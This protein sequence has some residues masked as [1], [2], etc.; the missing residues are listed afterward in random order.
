MNSNNRGFALI[1][2]L[3]SLLLISITFG[4]VATGVSVSRD[5]V[6]ST[7]K[8]I[9]RAIAYSIDEATIRNSLI[10][11]HFVFDTEKQKILVEG[12]E[13]GNFMLPKFL[14]TSS[15]DL[16]KE[17]LAN[18]Q[19]KLNNNFHPLKEFQDPVFE[20]EEDVRII[21]IATSISRQ[22]ITEGDAAVYFYPTGEKMMLSLSSVLMKRLLQSNFQLI[23]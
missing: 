8:E 12:G 6:E 17:E 10:R 22:L 19:K 1:E 4:L 7:E 9:E 16:S 2:I 18:Q 15:S 5:N 11:I 23:N 3:T 13:E 21:G 20:L 14:F